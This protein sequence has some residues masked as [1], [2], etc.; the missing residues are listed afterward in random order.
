M[1]RHRAFDRV[2]LWLVAAIALG[3]A[4]AAAQV[5]GSVTPQQVRESIRRATRFLLEEQ[6]PKGNW[7]EVAAYPGG[8]TALCTLALLN[9][10]VEPDDPRMQRALNY[11]RGLSPEKTYTVALQTM[12]FCAAEPSKDLIRIQ[13]NAKWLEI[14]QLPSGGWS[15]PD[16]AQ[17]G[18][19]SNSQF[20]VLALH[21][22]ERAG[23]VVRQETWEKAARYWRDCQNADGSWGYQPGWQQGTGSMTCAGIASTVIC[24]LRTDKRDAVIDDGLVSCCQLHE[25]DDSLERALSWLGNN[26][27]VKRNPGLRRMG[28]VWHYYYLYALERVGRLTARRLI[29]RFDWYREGT[30]FLVLEQ[31]QF[32]H[33]WT[34]SGT[35]ETNPQI[36]TAYSLLFLSKG[37]RPVLMSKLIHD[38]GDDWDNHSSDVANVTAAAEKAW[39]LDMT[40][41]LLNAD[42]SSVEDLLSTPVLFVSGSENPRLEPYA[43]RVRAYLDRGGFLFAEACCLDGEEFERGFRKFLDKV[44][45]EK[46]YRLR[47]AGPEHPLWRVERMVRPESPYAGR[48]W[49]VEYG[50][51]TC[52]AFCEVDLSC[53][54][55]LGGRLESSLEDLPPVVR[56]RVEDAYAIGLNV[57]AYATNREPQG[58]EQ[59]FASTQNLDELAG[60]G[61][62]GVI[63][64]AKLQHGG[65]CND[66]PGALVNLLRT[67]GQ[68][69]LRLSVDLDE[70]P[71]SP[72]DETLFRFHMAFMHGRNNFTF[73]PQERERLGEFLRN[74]GT[75]LADAICGSKEFA[76][77][78]RREMGQVLPDKPLRRLPVTHPLM[79][80]V[81]GG[82]DIRS[83]ER[84]DP[85]RSDP[86][87]P[88]RA[89]VLKGEPELEGI[90]IDGRLAV[91]FSPYDI[92]CALEQHESLECPGYSRQDAAR[93]ALN[94]LVYSLNPDA[95][96]AP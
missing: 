20:A 65:G 15:Y 22:A 66:A 23:A 24:G 81:A 28:H 25:E 6:S 70:Y 7:D 52:V 61:S 34:G 78:F 56:G 50:C 10:G 63:Q 39:G 11:L 37:R 68:G 32:S 2:V 80:D 77:A 84:R 72:A 88:L 60:I 45:P 96:A 36:T 46:E 57:L 76:E 26:F 86:G 67:A 73:T 21:E 1:L 44:F 54:W 5:P 85:A 62:R 12:V 27:S 82:F 89:R 14:K 93:I 16:G 33:H 31:D 43:E 48:M 95:A 51:R 13:K 69:E 58:K 47:R 59:S 75:L 55:E 79:N 19:N 4:G 90:E 30:Q 41:Q 92:S 29:D 83:V 9:A 42:G 71:V 38:P 35:Y 17:Q 94:V 87:E 91:V 64:I 74:G 53:Y 8:V 49:T 3:Q 40:W 18:D